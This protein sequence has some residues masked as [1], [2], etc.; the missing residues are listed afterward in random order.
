MGLEFSKEVRARHQFGSEMYREVTLNHEFNEMSEVGAVV[1]GG[2]DGEWKQE[3]GT[4][5]V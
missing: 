5:I 4:G 2:M 1:L 3:E